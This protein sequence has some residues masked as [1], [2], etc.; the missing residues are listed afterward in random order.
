MDIK[1]FVALIDEGYAM[2]PKNEWPRYGGGKLDRSKFVT[3]SEVGGCS[4]SIK[5]GKLA[6]QAPFKDWGYA[7]RGN[8]IE[9]WASS[10]IRAALHDNE[11]W[12]LLLSGEGQLSFAAGHQSATPDGILLH[13]P[14][15]TGFG[16]ELKSIDPRTNVNALPNPMHVDQ[17]QQGMD[18][19]NHLLPYEVSKSFL[20]YI[21]ASNLQ[22]RMPY[23]IEAD[24]A[25]QNEL[26][27]KAEKIM[28]AASP[29]D[30]EPEGMFMDKKVC[31][32]CDFSDECNKLMFPKEEVA[33]QERAMKDVFK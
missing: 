26:E 1:E 12:A 23:L 13:Y 3:A 31:G 2:Q 25:R 28:L 32:Y 24:Y 27:D 20:V 16:V 33:N 18:L 11:D 19:L 9:A 22:R 29:A 7:E 15:M 30:L 6:P 10:L 14:T 8:L 5:F 17:V 21:D 4:R